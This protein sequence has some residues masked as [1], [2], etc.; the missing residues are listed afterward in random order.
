MIFT[1]C[2]M[3]LCK[4]LNLALWHLEFHYNVLIL[5]QNLLVFWIWN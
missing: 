4:T 5:A 2:A 1:T 3:H